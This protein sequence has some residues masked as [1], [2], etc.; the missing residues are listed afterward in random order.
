VSPPRG[1]RFEIGEAV[2]L[3]ARRGPPAARSNVVRVDASNRL[4]DPNA[5]DAALVK[6]LEPVAVDVVIDGDDVQTS[7]RSR[8]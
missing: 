4:D 6:L 2:V 5:L 1:A 8:Q 7:R 3:A